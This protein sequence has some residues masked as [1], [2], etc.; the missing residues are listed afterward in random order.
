M[1]TNSVAPTAAAAA[2]A[3]APEHDPAGPYGGG[4]K[5]KVTPIPDTIPVA[6]WSDIGRITADRSRVDPRVQPSNYFSLE[7]RRA[8][9]E[10]AISGLEPAA[11]EWLLAQLTTAAQA[12]G[13]I[14]LEE[15]L[16]LL[17]DRVPASD[18]P[19]SDA[20]LMVVEVA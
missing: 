10:G 1:Q 15:A 6:E 17:S 13:D 18:T 5:G 19:H 9:V 8:W 2:A 14:D 16:V 12:D 4:V 7:D 11:Q 20:G 3:P